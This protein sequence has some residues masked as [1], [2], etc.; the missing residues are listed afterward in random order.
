MN[1]RDYKTGGLA[2]YWVHIILFTFGFVGRLRPASWHGSVAAACFAFLELPCF[3][4]DQRIVGWMWGLYNQ[5]NWGNNHNKLGIAHDANINKLTNTWIGYSLWF[6]WLCYLLVLNAGNFWEWSISSLVISSSQQPPA[7]HP[8]PT[9]STSTDW[10]F[11]TFFFHILGIIIP[12]DF[13]I[14]QRGSNHQPD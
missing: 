9:F 10:W 2:K 1:N 12:T 6:Q 5:P 4:E 13:H 7:T 11:G 8:F 3:A 14:F